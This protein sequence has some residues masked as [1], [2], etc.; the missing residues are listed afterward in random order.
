MTIFKSKFNLFTRTFILMASI[1]ALPMYIYASPNQGNLEDDTDKTGYRLGKKNHKN[2]R[3]GLTV[4]HIADAL[5]DNNFVLVPTGHA[6]IKDI[7]E[8]LIGKG[9]ARKASLNDLLSQDTKNELINI[10]FD[11][12]KQIEKSDQESVLYHLLSPYQFYVNIDQKAALTNERIVEN[13][14]I[15]DYFYSG[16]FNLLPPIKKERNYISFTKINE[17]DLAKTPS[18]IVVTASIIENNQY[19]LEEILSKHN[20]KPFFIKKLDDTIIHESTITIH[21]EHTLFVKINHSAIYE[22][23]SLDI[24]GIHKQKDLKHIVFC[25]TNH[26]ATSICDRFCNHAESVLSINM[27]GL[28]N[29][30]SIGNSF[31]W[32]NSLTSFS[33]AGLENVKSIGN[34]FLSFNKLTSFSSEGLENVTSID[35][36]F[37]KCNQLISFSC[38]GLEK[39]TSI[40]K[41]FLGLNRLT[42][43]SCE[44]LKKVTSIGK[45]FLWD[46]RIT[47]FSCK[48]LE[49][50]ISIGDYFLSNNQLTTFSS[51]GL[52]KVTSIGRGF[53]GSNQHLKSV[54]LTALKSIYFVGPY[55]LDGCPNIK[56]I[57]VTKEKEA[58]FRKHIPDQLQD[59]IIVVDVE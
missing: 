47:S 14:L 37:L 42:S 44:R 7:N 17:Q 11:G 18:H 33:C 27:L 36:D 54:D 48:G 16:I 3:E 53:L 32:H 50:V 4:E 35:D 41:S 40:G 15:D 45:S 25:D 31:L 59:K 22:D 28:T 49:S 6:L 43:F 56:E 46:N 19:Q 10:L 13:K 5:K 2:K 1:F 39:L 12:D 26:V 30:T 23:G 29:L 58:F 24:F 34:N 9:E 55:F 51:E 38:E 52:K 20:E 57:F 8:E 21:N